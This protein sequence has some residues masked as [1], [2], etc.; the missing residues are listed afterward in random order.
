MSDKPSSKLYH[1]GDPD[2]ESDSE[3]EEEVRSKLDGM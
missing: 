3:Y 2:S 1:S